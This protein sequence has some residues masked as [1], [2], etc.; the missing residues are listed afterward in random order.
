MQMLKDAG[1]KYVLCG[2]SERRLHH[3]ETDT[4]ISKQAAAALKAG[5]TP[6]VCIGETAEER[7]QGNAEAIVRRQVSAIP[8]GVILAY[9]PVWAIGT[10]KV[11][12]PEQA[13]QMHGFIR[14]LLPARL[15]QKTQ[16]LYGGSVNAEN[17]QMLLSQQDVDGVLVGGCSLKTEEFAQI[18]KV[19]EL[20]KR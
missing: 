12:T 9:E 5:L 18:V 7:A 6:I 13:Q 2:H 11:A 19:A 16:I 10:N 1:A 15:Q 20:L 14:G 8:T 4:Q 3:R 17:I